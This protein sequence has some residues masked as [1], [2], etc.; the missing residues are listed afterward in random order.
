MRLHC[1]EAE[2]A[3]GQVE[4]GVVFSRTGRVLAYTVGSDAGFNIPIIAGATVTHNHPRLENGVPCSTFSPIDVMLLCWEPGRA[5][6]R[7]FFEI[8]AV[9][10]RYLCSLKGQPFGFGAR[11]STFHVANEMDRLHPRPARLSYNS[12]E[13]EGVHRSLQE[14]A[15]RGGLSTPGSR[16]RSLTPTLLA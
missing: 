14:L 2:I 5:K 6:S 7:F 10:D 12:A 1:A 3:T 15:P 8:R 4:R 16:D 11:P 9:D 13:R